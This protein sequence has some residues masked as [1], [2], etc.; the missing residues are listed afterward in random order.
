MKKFRGI[1]FSCIDELNTRPNKQHQT[2]EAKH[3][4]RYKE[5]RR[6]EAPEEVKKTTAS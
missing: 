2:K 6:Q 5:G 3:G 1:Q 4:L